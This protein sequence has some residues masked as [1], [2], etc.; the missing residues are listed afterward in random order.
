MTRASD[1]PPGAASAASAASAATAP[2]PPCIV[3]APA[4]RPP[5][6]R[7]LLRAEIERIRLHLGRYPLETAAG[8]LLF[9]FM[10]LVFAALGSAM[11]GRL[12]PFGRD[13]RALA[14]LYALWMTAT[15]TMAGGAAQLAADAATGVLETLFLA[16]APVTRVLEARAV[17]HALHGL[18]SSAILLAA[19]CAAT[20]WWPPA[21]AWLAFGAAALAGALTSLGLAMALSGAALRFKRVGVLL[22]P[23]NFVCML[24]VMAGPAPSVIGHAPW[25]LALPFVAGSAALRGALETGHAAPVPMAFAVSSALV[26]WLAGRAILARSVLACR[27]AGTTH[28]Y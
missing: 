14:V 23:V 7:A 13:S 28:V 19:F 18:A 5:C 1:F 22:L 26:V 4:C 3:E 9:A 8:L 24:A 12:S 15:T 21:A 2:C 27:R 10:F 25:T 20:R 6:L 16:A 17:A 11:D